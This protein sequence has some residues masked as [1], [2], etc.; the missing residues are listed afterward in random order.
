MRNVIH[1]DLFENAAFAHDLHGKH[2]SCHAYIRAT[3]PSRDMVAS[4]FARAVLNRFGVASA[5]VK[6]IGRRN[7]YSM[8][9][10]LFNAIEKHQNIDEY[11]KSR[12]KRYLTLKWM[13]DKNI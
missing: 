6:L 4:P 1:I 8:V 10:A 3:P 13:M 2:N 7:P 9:R 5:S 11:A 12:G